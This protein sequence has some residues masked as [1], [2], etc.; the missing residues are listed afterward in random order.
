MT[1]IVKLPLDPSSVHSWTQADTQREEAAYEIKDLRAEIE[2]LRAERDTFY[3][4]YRMKCDAETKALTI[5]RDA[6]RE[7]LCECRIALMWP[8]GPA[9][10]FLDR[11]DAAT[12]SRTTG[13]EPGAEGA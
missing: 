3:M 1:D 11:I 6:L 13:T 8:G 12:A 5:E 10:A 9:Q 7:L 2:R 4:D